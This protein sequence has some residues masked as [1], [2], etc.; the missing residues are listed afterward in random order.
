MHKA[1]IIFFGI[2]IV[3]YSL[4]LFLRLFRNIK[5]AMS[6]PGEQPAEITLKEIFVNYLLYSGFLCHLFA[7]I[8]RWEFSGHPPIMGTYESAL[9]GSW[10]TVSLLILFRRKY[11][12]L[13]GVQITVMFLSIALMLYG[14]LFPTAYIPLTISEQSLWVDFHALFAWLAYGNYV[15]ACACALG[16]LLHIPPFCKGGKGDQTHTNIGRSTESSLQNDIMFYTLCLGFFFQTLMMATGSY[17]NFILFGLWWRWDPIESIAL[18]CWIVSALVIHTRLFYNWS[19]K[20][21]A[22]IVIV[23]FSFIVLMHKIFPFIPR[24]L[25]F[26]NF[27]IEF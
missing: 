12:E 5:K 26:H 19:G 10:T 8:I 11:P 27:D 22:T 20:R 13:M 9:A 6:T 2:S 4:W 24:H 3:L 25:T 18:I 7:I 15:I 16:I 23:A 21:L 1:E 17:Y 14:L